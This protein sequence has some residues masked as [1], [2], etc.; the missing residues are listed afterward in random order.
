MHTERER[1]RERETHTHIHTHTHTFTHTIT[2]VPV[3]DLMINSL[4]PPPLAN[5]LSTHN[6]LSTSFSVTHE[7]DGSWVTNG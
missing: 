4:S 1:E 7:Q 3:P 6:V 2:K 5:V